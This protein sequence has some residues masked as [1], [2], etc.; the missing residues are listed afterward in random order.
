MRKTSVSSANTRRQMFASF[1]DSFTNGSL[2][3]M[4]HLN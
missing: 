4:L 2:L 1:A 3:Q